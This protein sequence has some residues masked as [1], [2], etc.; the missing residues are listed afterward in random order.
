MSHLLGAEELNRTLSPTV[1]SAGPA[2]R[3]V[4]F[5]RGGTSR[6]YRESFDLY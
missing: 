5:V 3:N 6:S 2:L 1:D 4:P